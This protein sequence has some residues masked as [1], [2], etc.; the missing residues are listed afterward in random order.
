MMRSVFI[1]ILLILV[2]FL[3]FGQ[4]Q[5]KHIIMFYNVENLFD[6]YDD[7]VVRD[8]EFT[9]DGP[10]EWTDAKYRKKLGNIEEVIYSVA[11]SKHN[12]P[13]II[14]VSEI[15][16]RRVLDDLVSTSKLARANYQIVHYDSPLQTSLKSQIILP[17]LIELS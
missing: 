6:I 13:A 9:P 16:N 2:S 15:E 17:D 3:S 5:N 1:S 11:A 10:K 14:G 8:D 7:P 4:E 12:Y